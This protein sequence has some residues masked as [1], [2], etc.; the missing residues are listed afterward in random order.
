VKTG[1][2]DG[3]R[4]DG[5]GDRN[6]GDGDRNDGDGDGDGLRANRGLSGRFIF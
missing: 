4:N 3:D 5:D 1:G 6:D 2:G